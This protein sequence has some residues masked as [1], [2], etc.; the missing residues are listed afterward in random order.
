MSNGLVGSRNR[1]Q[2]HL[3]LFK[4]S[5]SPATAFTRSRS[6][7]Y[8]QLFLIQTNDLPSG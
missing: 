2:R 6:S 7:E 4:A 3:T 1:N 8:R 5:E